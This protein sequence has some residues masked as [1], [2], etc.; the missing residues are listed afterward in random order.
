M[1]VINNARSKALIKSYPHNSMNRAR[2]TS[3]SLPFSGVWLTTAPLDSLFYL[4][5]V[6]FSLAV[7]LRLGITPYDDVVRCVCG[8]SLVESPLHFQSCRHLSGTRIIRHDRLVQVLARISRLC[9]VVVQIEPR[10]D[11]DD[12][13]RTHNFDVSVVD[14]GA[15]TYVRAAQRPLGAAG[16]IEKS[17]N[18]QYAN[19]CREQG[20]LFSPVVLEC[21]GDLGVCCRDLCS[22]IEEEGSLNGVK[23]IHGIKIKSY[24]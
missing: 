21:F 23:S 9:G 7:R 11:G 19:R 12:K 22:K 10:V 24:L 3:L 15:K 2:L 1:T 20:S 8:A 5:D 13:S 6:H 4:H 18:D 17:K 14:P 16:V